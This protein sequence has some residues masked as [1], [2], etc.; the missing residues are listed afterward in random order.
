MSSTFDRLNNWARK[1]VTLKLFVIGF[2]IL[3]LLIPANMLQSLIRE[4]ES[5]RN[6]A[7]EEVSAKW[8]LAQ[9]IG[10]P[11]IS[12]PYTT[13]VIDSEG[14][15]I[16]RTGYAHFLPDEIVID[17]EL[18]PEQRY[19]GIYV[20][21]LYQASL[22]INGHF[23][24]LNAAALQIP[25]G[26]LHWEDALFTI[27]I[28]DMAGVRDAISLVLNDTSLQFGP[29]TVTHDIFSAGASVPI[30]LSERPDELRFAF[31]LQLNGSSTLSFLPFGKETRVS[32]SSPWTDPS[33]EGAFLPD[34]RT[35][36]DEGFRASW[37]VLHLNRNYPQ[38]GE[39][40]YIGKAADGRLA[41]NASDYDYNTKA[42]QQAAN[43]PNAFGLRLLLPIDEYHKSMRTAKYAA[44]FIFITFLTFFFIEVLNRKRLHPIQY[45]LIG[46]AIILFYVLLV[47]IA[48]HLNFD[49]A[50]WISCALIVL[51]IT[52]YSAFV[53]GNRKL[54]FLVA[55]MLLVLYG[56]F[57]SILQLQDYALLLG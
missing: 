31:N 50:Y 16:S 39:G 21:V 53:L 27:G 51:L 47:S 18:T 57:Y 12:V 34:E 20:V 55:A 11:V 46:A 7:I 48:E 35:V 4:R 56:F 28:S 49:T 15:T 33:F 26:D 30:D 38:Q 40:A 52:G 23:G 14:K 3:L 9:T 54:T 25:V 22:R 42:Y 1:S 6:S 10:G 37:K 8:G 5:L 32:L 19:R 17:G 43:D 13:S 36:N 45:L 41:L 44:F 24:P 2:L 29:G